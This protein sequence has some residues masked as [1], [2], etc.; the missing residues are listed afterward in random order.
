MGTAA[1]IG[2]VTAGASAVG[3]VMGASAKK[4]AIDLG[5]QKEQLNIQSE[6]TQ[7]SEQLNRSVSHNMVSASASGTSL[8]SQSIT[9][10]TTNDFHNYGE[11]KDTYDMESQLVDLNA[12]SS[13]SQVD[14]QEFSSLASAGAGAYSMYAMGDNMGTQP[15][16]TPT[17]IA[18]STSSGS[19]GGYLQNC[20][21]LS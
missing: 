2:G 12:Q 1:V 8:G 17:T 15:G 9:A 11:D 13:K 4:S 3:A 14:A 6:K 5:A 20:L 10:M 19:S 21:V 7:E 16:T 18:V